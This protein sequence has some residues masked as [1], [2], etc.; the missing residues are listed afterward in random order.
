MT[1]YLKVIGRKG[2]ITYKFGGKYLYSNYDPYQEA[3]SFIENSERKFGKYALTF[4][5]AD[6]VNKALLQKGYQNI[7]SFEPIIFDKLTDSSAILRLRSIEELETCIV[8]NNINPVQIDLF[9]WRPF[10]E[11]DAQIYLEYLTQIKNILNKITLSNKTEK[12]FGFVETRNFLRNIYVNN[13]L[14]IL[15]NSKKKANPALIIASGYSLI[16][17]VE[18]IKS[19]INKA[20]LIALPSALHF[21]EALNITPDLSIVTDPGYPSYYHLSKFK[22]NISIIAPLSIQPTITFLK[23]YNFLFFNYKSFLDEFFFEGINSAYSPPEGSVIFN[24]LNI[25]PQ[26]GFD[27]S[28]IVGLDFSYYKNRSHINEGYFERE[29]FTQS[30][31]FKSIDFHLKRISARK[32]NITYSV[33]NNTFYSDISLKIYYDHFINRHYDLEI[34]APNTCYNP[35]SD[36]FKK[37]GKDFFDTYEN[38]SN[39]NDLLEIREKVIDNN[40]L[41][42]LNNVLYNNKNMLK[43]YLYYS[44]ESSLHKLFLKKFKSATI[45]FRK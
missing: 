28:I 8:E 9:I 13:K 32:D 19:A 20:Y 43:D 37:I 12:Y 44:D 21:L 15:C 30:D 34:L 38:K 11:T 3:V 41:F 40:L 36:K 23:N 4:C 5:G 10:I 39:I 16:D 22:K 7:L 25:L 14:N 18:F 1:N 45:D 29:Y 27:T 2:F 31:Y 42:K 26:I 6:Y 33:G 17:N 24:L 35:L